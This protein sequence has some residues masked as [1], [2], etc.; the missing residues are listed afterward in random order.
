MFQKESIT[1]DFMIRKLRDRVDVA[2]DAVNEA[3]ADREITESN[4]HRP[5][6]ALAGY[7]D[8]F[9]HQR[10]Q[11]LGNTEHRFLHHLDA[12]RQVEAFQNITQFDL[13]C[14]IGTDDNQLPDR[15]VDLATEADI[16]VY[17][18]S[19]PTVEFMASLRAFLEDQFAP[20]C[21]VHGSLVDVY[22]IGLLLI[23]KPGIGK[24]EVALDLV[25]RGHRLVADDVII[26]TKRDE[27]ILMGSG[28][29]L[30]QHFMEVRG[31]GLVDI[32]SMF[33]IR[34]IRFQKRIEVVVNMQLWDPDKE[35]TRIHM[36]EDT[37]E[38]LNVDLPMVQVPITPGK[39]ITVIC[40]VIA[41]NYLLKH[42]GYDPAEVFGERLRARI[43]DNP[44][45]A[46]RR[47]VEYFEQ[48]FE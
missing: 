8:L 16:P 29:D 13:P 41:M 27:Q 46:S 24:S 47:R 5:G 39:N 33:G 45:G 40:E 18:T 10:V 19:L 21:S 9:T 48:D 32:R 17:R 36:V 15:L 37:H 35:Y 14:I 26:A 3:D 25:E 2:V 6:L 4:L 42:Y 1:V 23:G 30:V 22:G 43:R 11:I 34:A 28:T 12:D 38:I 44:E 20:Q 7:V 31:L